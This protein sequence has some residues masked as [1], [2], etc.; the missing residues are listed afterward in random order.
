MYINN[1]KIKRTNVLIHKIYTNCLSLFTPLK[2]VFNHQQL[3]MFY[4]SGGGVL[5]VLTNGGHGG[6]GGGGGGGHG[7]G[8]YC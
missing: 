5:K 8:K 7:H 3:F 4:F 2:I 1:N 6:H